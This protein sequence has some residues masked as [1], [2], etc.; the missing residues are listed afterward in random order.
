MLWK[1]KWFETTNAI[2]EEMY[3]NKN[4]L[5]SEVYLSELI[6]Q[7]YSRE[8]YRKY[9]YKYWYCHI[10]ENAD[11]VTI[12]CHWNTNISQIKSIWNTNALKIQKQKN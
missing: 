10:N 4:T 8:I 12:W 1:L 6:I 3:W 11:I 5:T 7:M 2:Q 9:K